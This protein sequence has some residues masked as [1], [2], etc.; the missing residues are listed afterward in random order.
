M[1][2]A[3]KADEYSAFNERSSG[4]CVHAFKPM[5]RVNSVL[6]ARGNVWTFMCLYMFVSV[7]DR[8][9]ERGSSCRGQGGVPGGS[10]RRQ[11]QLDASGGGQ[12][13]LT[14]SRGG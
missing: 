1:S 11:T 3:G 12:D 8:E 5:C 4:L 14:A 2:G 7:F 10:T 6:R 13:V 9:M